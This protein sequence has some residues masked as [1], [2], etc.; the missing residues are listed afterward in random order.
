MHK[1]ATLIAATILIVASFLLHRLYGYLPV[2]IAVMLAS[3]T[4]AGYPVVR[5]A[6]GALRYRIVGI[7]V[8]VS[9]AT[10]GAILI[11]EY[12]EA[13]AVTYLF[14]FG[15]YLE[16]RT[17]EKTRSSI[18]EL[19]NLAP[20]T[21]RVLKNGR[22]EVV[23]PKSV[24]QGDRVIIKPGER[25]AVDGTVEDGL[26][27]VNQSTVTGESLPVE[28]Q[29]GQQVFA[30]TVVESGYLI[31]EAEKVGDQTT[32]ARILELV[33]EA[34]DAK[35]K[36]QKFLERFSQYYTPGIMVLSLAL[37]LFTRD[38]RL[39]LTLLVIACPGALVISAPVSIVAGI[40]NG[41]KKGILVKG[42]DVMERLG[43]VQAIAFDKTGTV[44]KGEPEVVSLQ[45][46]DIDRDDLLAIAASGETYAEHPIAKAI[47]GYGA[48]RLSQNIRIPEETNPIAGKGVVFVLEG[49]TYLLGNRALFADHGISLELH[50]TAI[51]IE[52]KQAR[53]VVIVGDSVRVLGF[54]AIAD[55][56]RPQAKELLKALKRIGIRHVVM[57][58]G[59]NERT[60][61]T[62]AGQLGFDAYR[63]SL[64]PQDK[65]KALK[66]LQDEYGTVA[67]VGDGVN[68]A[69]ALATADLGVAIGG[70]GSD[71]AMETADVIIM[72]SHLSM[73]T[74]AVGLS[75]AT[76]RNMKQN[77]V[78]AILVAIILLAGVLVRTVDLSFGM[79]V[80]EFSVLLVILNAIRLMGYGKK[81]KL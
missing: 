80:H 44:T 33:E 13:A 66:E 47:V 58:T 29:V 11:G 75:R 78:F 52:E 41:A 32:F 22:E 54:F 25:I 77:I 43:T 56:V 81:S 23:D 51:R 72:S 73:L 3:T 5:K 12:W 4:L 36:T 14:L 79:L 42:G 31:I 9:V 50:E 20:E 34:Q 71:V 38:I 8:L 16:A 24:T 68:D 26:A 35:A 59:D 10:V 48:K 74:H 1:T 64:L 57:L 76:V 49:K 65:V 19:L 17:L 39:S 70:A 28:R 6:I 18:K 53:T 40:G 69:P 7:E 67:M 30:G 62:I 45:A 60:A 55:M 2:T 21:A 61:R 15:G 46:F 27:Y 63:A 37:F